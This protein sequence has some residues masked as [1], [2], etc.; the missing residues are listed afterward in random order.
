M[1]RHSN[2]IGYL[3]ELRDQENI[4]WFFKICDLAISSDG[5]PLTNDELQFLIEIFRGKDSYTPTSAKPKISSVTSA[6]RAPSIRSHL[7]EIGRF[8][9]FKRL[10]SELQVIFDKRIM[11]IFGGNA[12]G[13][14]SLC[15]AIKLLSN[16]EIP[17]N[18]INDVRAQS[19]HT[20]SFD[21]QF[22]SD[23]GP[24]TWDQSQG[25]GIFADKIKYFDS[26]IAIQNITG[27]VIPERIIKIEPFRL[28]VFTFAGQ[29]IR[30]LN[31]YLQRLIDIE[32]R[33]LSQKIELIKIKFK[34]VLLPDERAITGLTNMDCVDLEQTISR[35]H[36]IEE[37][38]KEDHKN[39][40]GLL[41]RLKT[42]RN[43][44]GLKL[45]KTEIKL[46]L[47]YGHSIKEFINIV[48]SAPLERAV[49]IAKALSLKKELQRELAES[50]TPEGLDP[51][52][53]QEF[54][55]ASEKIFSYESYETEVCP[56]CRRSFDEASIQVVEKYHQFLVDKIG[57]EIR[58][59]EIELIE[60]FNG[61]SK[62][63]QYAIKGNI[64]TI[65]IDEKIFK[66]SSFCIE[67]IKKPIPH[68]IEL[69]E[70][71]QVEGYSE[72]TVL[73]ET[74]SIIAKAIL[75]RYRAI[76]L[77]S[78]EK[79]EFQ[80]RC[81]KLEDKIHKFSYS[82]CFDDN[83]D[84]IKDVVGSVNYLK[85]LRILIHQAGF[86]TLLRKVTIKGKDAYGDLV[87][88]EFE[89][90]L[91]KEYQRMSGKK[92]SDFG[93]TL[94][95]TGADQSVIVDTKV[96][97]EPIHRVFSE[98][99]QKIH[100]L[101]M[102]FGEAY[103]SDHH[104]VIFDDPVTSFDYNYSAIYAERLRD[105]IKEKPE[106][107]VIVLTH[108]WDFF[109]NLQIVLNQSGLN[110]KLS[111]KVMEDCCIVKEYSENIVDL[112]TEI[113]GIL[114]IAV[115]PSKS[116]KDRLSGNLRRLIE[117]IVNKYV[118]NNERHQFKQKTIQISVFT[119]F[120]KLVPLLPIEADKLRDLYRKLSVPEHED[121]RNYYS[122]IG[123]S[124]Y[125]Q[126]YTEICGIESALI[127]RRP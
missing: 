86:P 15:E 98:G 27:S 10:S 109:A 81:N 112:K 42:A 126:W 13:K 83:L 121:P 35:H 23:S 9:N 20:C 105:Y 67:A 16:P 2:A 120:I 91:D 122:R 102:F 127:A 95:S 104:I 19:G 36:A 24:S 34:D 93:I 107:Q 64:E 44:E 66:R 92:M 71:V 46:L 41:E 11:L 50:I 125:Q 119:K 56:F 31:E 75:Q 8:I 59:L 68:Q 61:L 17:R 77:S 108:N 25:Y 40:V 47:E 100:A 52:H 115:E 55:K 88:S 28:E 32:N 63:R 37:K 69:L 72:F 89:R 30:E 48:I 62:V 79:E 4:P 6:F 26:T 96:G 14:T 1:S 51:N 117:A 101:A 97:N 116:E 39:D 80:K 74:I 38:E 53:F 29:Y 54:I 49:G 45:Q 58:A 113:E 110:D 78:W 43:I 111:V 118:F 99:E 21:Y 124:S 82:K 3:I 22:S 84:K 85:N 90:S 123:R 7:K 114:G 94:T 70:K 5:S 33:R 12:S 65:P 57:K 87:V 73:K 103:V 60:L 106:D 76:R 18:P